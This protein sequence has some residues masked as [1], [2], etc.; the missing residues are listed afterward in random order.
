[1]S[2]K[3]VITGDIIQSRKIENMDILIADLKKT[4]SIIQE[5]LLKEESSLEIYRGDSFQI[6]LNE[7]HQALRVSLIIKS[8][9]KSLEIVSTNNIQADARISIGIGEIKQREDSLS[10]SQGEAFELSGIELD[11]ITQSKLNISIKT[12]TKT[13][14]NEF[15]VN[16]LFANYLINNWTK[17]TAESIYRFLLFEETQEQQAY[18]LRTSQ[19]NINK[20]LNKYGNID[21]IVAFIKQFE[22]KIISHYE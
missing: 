11:K 17:K 20:R 22:N 2:I 18:I 14:N 21:A 1:M 7:A 15:E 9:L 4:F 3:S 12:N 19:P 10:E 5:K 8:K 6:L 16:C 13:L